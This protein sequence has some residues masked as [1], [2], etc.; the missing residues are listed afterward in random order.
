MRGPH[1]LAAQL[2]VPVIWIMP[3]GFVSAVKRRALQEFSE[4]LHASSQFGLV[5]V[6]SSPGFS[7]KSHGKS[8]PARFALRPT[9]CL[10][11]SAARRKPGSLLHGRARHQ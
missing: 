4:G 6:K 10:H 2:P 8:E 1:R 3:G 11:L 7:E 5:T 9:R